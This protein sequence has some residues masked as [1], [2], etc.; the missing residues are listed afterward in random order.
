MV[1]SVSL[2]RCSGAMLLALL[3]CSACDRAEPDGAFRE[4]TEPFTKLSAECWPFQGESPFTTPWLASSVELGTSSAT[5]TVEVFGSST[6]QVTSELAEL[7]EPADS[8]VT[9][10][11]GHGPVRAT[12]TAPALD[13]ARV[14]CQP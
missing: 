1:K 10:P 14:T 13:A 12:I 4:L 6:D 7:A 8:T 2:A 5:L 9:P 11:E 3:L